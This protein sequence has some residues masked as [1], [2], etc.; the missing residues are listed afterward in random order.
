MFQTHCDE[1]P[2]DSSVSEMLQHSHEQE[3]ETA[4]PQ[5]PFQQLNKT[6]TNPKEMIDMV[7]VIKTK[8]CRQHKTLSPDYQSN[9]ERE[10][11][12]LY[13]DKAILKTQYNKKKAENEQLRAVVY[14]LECQIQKTQKDYNAKQAVC[15]SK[16]EQK[17]ELIDYLSE[18]VR[19]LQQQ[20]AS[21][22]EKLAKHEKLKKVVQDLEKKAELLR[23]QIRSLSDELSH[24]EALTEK[25]KNDNKTLKIDK[26]SLQL[27]L[28]QAQNLISKQDDIIA[29]QSCEIN[30]NH[31]LIEELRQRAAEIQQTIRD[32]HSQAEQRKEEK[33]LA[34]VRSL[35]EEFRLL[36]NSSIVPK[37]LRV[38]RL[39]KVVLQRTVLGRFA[40]LPVDMVTGLC[41]VGVFA[42]FVVF[43]TKLNAC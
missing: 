27:Q 34:C 24:H 15:E 9:P 43:K 5:P 10:R 28:K 19:D 40:S 14:G 18:D 41:T 37:E 2:V 3:E 16:M 31:E 12:A 35:E 23:K 30:D 32:L 8:N 38:E 39:E 22:Q 4:E 42:T 36:A 17:Q 11:L 33:V 21:L 1:R 20:C 29:R 7:D 13:D 25:Q 26:Q 6:N